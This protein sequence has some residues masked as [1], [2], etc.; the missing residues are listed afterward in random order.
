VIPTGGLKDW[1][2]G[3]KVPEFI[4][5]YKVAGGLRLLYQVWKPSDRMSADKY[6]IP[7]KDE[8]TL[9]EVLSKLQLPQCYPHDLVRRRYIPARAQPIFGSRENRTGLADSIIA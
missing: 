3:R 6:T 9:K 8:D 4:N 7:F 5:G 1:L 2:P